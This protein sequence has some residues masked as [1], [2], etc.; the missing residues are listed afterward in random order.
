MPVNIKIEI[1]WQMQQLYKSIFAVVSV[2]R[3]KRTVATNGEEQITCP[4]YHNN[5]FLEGKELEQSNVT[6]TC[7]GLPATLF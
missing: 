2:H 3:K 5:A 7:N 1:L 6:I 4:R